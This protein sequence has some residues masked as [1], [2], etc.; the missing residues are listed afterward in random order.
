MPDLRVDAGGPVV[1]PPL[2]PGPAEPPLPSTGSEIFKLLT[3]LMPKLDPLGE[4]KEILKLEEVLAFF[5]TD[6]PPDFDIRAGLLLRRQLGGS[7]LVAQVFL[8]TAG[9]L[10][11]DSLGRPYGRI[12]RTLEFDRALQDLFRHEDLIVFT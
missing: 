5:S 12:F 9:T 1:P 10:S 7:Y 4:V 8:G 6:T 3:K 2:Q 11:C